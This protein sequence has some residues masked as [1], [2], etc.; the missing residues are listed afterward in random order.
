[1][2]STTERLFQRVSLSMP[3]GRKLLLSQAPP[4]MSIVTSAYRYDDNNDNNKSSF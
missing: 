1:M 3:L 2:V 4:L